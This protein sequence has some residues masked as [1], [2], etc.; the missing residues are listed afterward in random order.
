MNWNSVRE[1]AKGNKETILTQRN[2]V[3]SSIAAGIGPLKRPT[4]FGIHLTCPILLNTAE[5][6][7]LHINYPQRFTV[8]QI[9]RL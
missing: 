1:E 2:C 7:A 5:N 4:L 6:L 8:R 3:L 9:E